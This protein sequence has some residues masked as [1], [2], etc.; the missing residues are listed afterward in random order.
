MHMLNPNELRAAVL[1]APQ[2]F[3]LGCVGAQQAGRSGRHRGNISSGA[4]SP[5]KPPKD[6][7]SCGMGAGHLYHE[8]AFDLVSG[9]RALDARQTG[10]HGNL[11]NPTARQPSGRN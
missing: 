8:S 7:H 1:K 9:F 4:V 5:A 11:G 10:V 6:S 2:G 3:D